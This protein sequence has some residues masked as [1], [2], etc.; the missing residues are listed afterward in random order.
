MNNEFIKGVLDAKISGLL[1]ESDYLT[2]SGLSGQEQLNFFIN[3][4]LVS[5]SI[6]TNFE[7]LCKH[8]LNDLKMEVA[9]YLE[10]DTFYINYFFAKD[11]ISRDK[12]ALHRFYINTYHEA[13][14]RQDEWLLGYLDLKFSLL[15]VLSIVRAKSRGD[16]IETIKDLYLP[17]SIMSEEVYISLINNDRSTLVSYVKNTF[18]ID[19]YDTDNNRVIEEKLDAY[20]FIKVKDLAIEGDLLPTLI[21]YIKMKKYEIT[22]LRD[23]YYTG[24]NK[25]HG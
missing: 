25:A 17:Q 11:Y 23:I 6:V 10:K 1:T 2:F 13:E 19:L 7:A 15:N 8:A 18:N 24:R 20:L 5:T 14:N 4:G 9:S 3:N 21:Y 12:N 22:R 16:Q